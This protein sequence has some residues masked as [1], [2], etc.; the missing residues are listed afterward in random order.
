MVYYPEK[1]FE[2]EILDIV[3]VAI[4]QHARCVVDAQHMMKQQ[5]KVQ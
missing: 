2:S 4:R 5:K 3:T 1:I